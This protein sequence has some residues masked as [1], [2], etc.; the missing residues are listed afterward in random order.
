MVANPCPDSCAW[1]DRQDIYI[2]GQSEFIRHDKALSAGGMS[3]CDRFQL[4]KNWMQ[5][6]GLVCEIQTECRLNVSGFPDGCRW[7]L[8]TRSV[9]LSSRS[10][11]PSGST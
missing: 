7:V 1:I 8:R 4:Q 5:G 11:M 9:S 3:R 6:G 2:D 10:A